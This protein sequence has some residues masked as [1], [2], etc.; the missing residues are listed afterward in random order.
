M[1][2]YPYILLFLIGFTAFSCNFLDESSPNDLAANGAITD[3][4]SAEAALLGIYS[5]MQNNSYY[6]FQYMVIGDALADNA[7]TGGYQALSLDQIGAKELTSANIITESMWV[8]IYRVIANANAL[9]EALPKVSDLEPKEKNHLEGQARA[10]R[11][12]AHFDL[13][14]L[15]GE[16]NKLNSAFGVPIV[17]TVQ[18]INDKP[19]RASVSAVYD[20]VLEE[21]NKAAGQL[22][23]TQT[24]VQYLNTHGVNALL[25]RVYL[26]KKDL[27]KAAEF[28]DKVIKSNAYKLLPAAEYASIY[29][30]RRTAESVFEL[31]FDS[32][33]RSGFNG[34]TYSRDDAI[35][36]ELDYM[37]AQGL[38]EFFKQSP[39]DVRAQMLDYDPQNNDAT[40]VPDGRTQKYR[41][42]ESKDNPAYIIRYAEVLLIMAEA[43]GGVQGLVFLNQL[44]KARGLSEI[45]SSNATE[46]AQALLNERRAEFNFEGQRMFDLART[47]SVKRVLGVDDFR[48]ILPIPIREI[49]ASGDAIKQN[50]G[51]E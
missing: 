35:R 50:P 42:E 17:K 39:S 20:F 46:F 9:I 21:L 6:G 34:G 4:A 25:A 47:G 13:L 43:R 18:T 3:G 24:Q 49:T 22:D 14:R 2:T 33:N 27:A 48:G 44:R 36:P 7:S 23:P 30:S 15:F 38:G 10:L 40:I 29:T 28:A 1:R 12:M 26:Y 11:A 51:Y 8:A 45:A 31:S 32:Q 19:G 5:A 37:A 16:H 41:G